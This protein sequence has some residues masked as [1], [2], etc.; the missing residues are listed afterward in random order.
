MK[1]ILLE[2]HFLTLVYDKG[3]ESSE[4]IFLLRSCFLAVNTNPERDLG[5]HEIH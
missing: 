5:R 4:W 3:P 1:E 2:N